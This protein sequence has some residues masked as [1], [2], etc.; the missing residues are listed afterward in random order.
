MVKLEIPSLND[1]RSDILALAAFFLDRFNTKFS[2]NITWFS[3]G[4]EELLTT[5]HWTGNVRELKN[6]MERGVLVAKGS[7]L[8]PRDMGFSEPAKDLAG[9]GAN[10]LFPPLSPDGVDLSL[11]QEQMEQF[12]IS[13]ALRLSKGNESQAAKLLNINHHTFRYRRKKFMD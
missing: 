7:K 13:E 1:R 11:L 6:L 8:T 2:K 12:Y 3:P 10:A 9:A 5:H 4:A